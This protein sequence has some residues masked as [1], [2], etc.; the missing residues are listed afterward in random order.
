MLICSVAYFLLVPC[1]SH[2]FEQGTFWMARLFIYGTS[3]SLYVYTPE[4]FTTEVRARGHG[5]CVASAQLG[6]MATPLISVVLLQ[7][8]DAAALICYAA[9]CMAAAILMVTI[10]YETKGR[11]IGEV[12]RQ[13][14]SERKGSAYFSV[15]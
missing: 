15:Q 7:A 10:P 13:I 5:L 12:F 3:Q 4:I 11:P 8:S 6:G 1:V 9:S 14:L 2:T